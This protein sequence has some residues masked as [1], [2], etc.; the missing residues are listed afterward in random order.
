ML[1]LTLKCFLQDYFKVNF[2]FFNKIIQSFWH[3]STSHVIVRFM[4]K[5]LQDSIKKI[6]VDIKINLRKHINDIVMLTSSVSLERSHDF[7]LK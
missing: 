6:E 3:E 5:R 7:G 1:L 4:L 2:D